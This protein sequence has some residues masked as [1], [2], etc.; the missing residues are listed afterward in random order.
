[1]NRETKIQPRTSAD[2]RES[3][4]QVVTLNRLKEKQKQYKFQAMLWQS[5]HFA[6]G[7]MSV[8]LAAVIASESAMP[9]WAG[10][11]E[12]AI[13]VT[14][15]AALSTFLRPDA[16]A[17]KFNAARH[18]LRRARTVHEHDNHPLANALNEADDL[19]LQE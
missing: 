2:S 9:R 1:M 13:V 4:K 19:V 12:M 10:T 18:V 3:E 11:E 6:L 8:S 14:I 17:K 16:R 7:G 15:S 5:I